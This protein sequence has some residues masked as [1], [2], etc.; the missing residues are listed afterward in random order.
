MELVEI[1]TRDE[2]SD[3]TVS[4]WSPA[5]LLGFACRLHWAQDETALHPQDSAWV[6][7][8]LRSM[9]ELKQRDLIRQ[10]D[11]STF[12]LVDFEGPALRVLALDA[13]LASQVSIDHNG[14]L[15]ENSLRYHPA[16][17]DWRLTLRLKIKDPQRPVKMY[18]ALIKDNR[19]LT[20]I[21]SYQ[22]HAKE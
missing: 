7:Q 2:T 8:T 11:G 12:L 3:N 16:I 15:L 14:E 6:R 19:R 22:L 13:P 4:F 1:P 10:A 17:Q 20:E 5:S 21:W 18:A 9:E